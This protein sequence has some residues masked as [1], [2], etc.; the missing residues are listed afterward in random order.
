MRMPL[1]MRICVYGVKKNYNKIVQ[2]HVNFI[3]ECD[4][5]ANMADL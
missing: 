2:V 1:C 5:V 4:C 3:V